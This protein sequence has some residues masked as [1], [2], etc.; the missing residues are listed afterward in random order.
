MRRTGVGPNTI[1]ANQ[2]GLDQVDEATRAEKLGLNPWISR[3]TVR[4]RD[5]E[6]NIQGVL[7][8]YEVFGLAALALKLVLI[9]ATVSRGVLKEITDSKCAAFP[10]TVF[11]TGSGG[12]RS[13]EG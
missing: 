12:L 4:Q 3:D 13:T 7:G 1:L 11:V 2:S 6:S 5:R 10:M 8:G 9:D